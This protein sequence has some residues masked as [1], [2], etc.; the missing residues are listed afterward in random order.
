M[1]A[2]QHLSDDQL[3]DLLLG[4]ADAAAAD[5]SAACPLCYGKLQSFATLVADF[6]Q[7]SLAWSQARSAQRPQV[8]ASPA[9]APRRLFTTPAYAFAA[10]F[11]VLVTILFGRFSPHPAAH[12]QQLAQPAELTASQPPAQHAGPDPQIAADNNLLAQ[13]DSALEQPDPAP[14]APVPFAPARSPDT[15]PGLTPAR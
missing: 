13:I 12:P 11:L 10:T 4:E 3:E 8:L 2:N 14:F 1:T 5:H 6:N 9:R 15:Q 7:S